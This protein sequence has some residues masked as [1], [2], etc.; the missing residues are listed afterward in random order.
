MVQALKLKGACKRTGACC[1]ND[2]KFVKTDIKHAPSVIEHL[3]TRGYK[4]RQVVHGIIQAEVHLPCP[5]L[6]GDNICKVQKTKPKICSDF[7]DEELL[8]ELISYGFDPNKLLHE[9]CGFYFDATE[10]ENL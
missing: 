1:R 5:E 4:I 8:K 3:K 9:G 7:P 10:E 2:V 6:E